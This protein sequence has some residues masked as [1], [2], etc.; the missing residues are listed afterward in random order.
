MGVSAHVL[1]C[2]DGCRDVWMDATLTQVHSAF[3]E[4]K[5]KIGLV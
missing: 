5:A 1:R 3:V 4:T 2:W